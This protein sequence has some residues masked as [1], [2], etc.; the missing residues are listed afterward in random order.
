MYDDLARTQRPSALEWFVLNAVIP[1]VILTLALQPGSSELL[2]ETFPRAEEVEEYRG[3]SISDAFPLLIR[4]PRPVYPELMRRHHV[5]GRV[6][7]RALVNPEGRVEPASITAPRATDGA[8][9]APAA[10][11]LELAL[12]IPARFG[13]HAGAAWV[14]ITIAL[15][16]GQE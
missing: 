9:V 6:V 13:G 5:D 1:S 15:S 2:P 8:F 16:P 4:M 3:S 7:L 11:A 12:F 14:T 10:R